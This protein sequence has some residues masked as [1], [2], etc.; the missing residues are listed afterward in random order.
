MTF[1]FTALIEGEVAGCLW[2]ATYLGP[3][4][5]ISQK[6][7]F[8]FQVF[9]IFFGH[10]VLDNA[11]G[12]EEVK[13]VGLVSRY[14]SF[15]VHLPILHYLVEVYEELTGSDI[16]L[17]LPF[18]DVICVAPSKHKQASRG[19]LAVERRERWLFHYTRQRKCLECTC[20]MPVVSILER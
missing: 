8:S 5:R 3:G 18:S 1:V 4:T 2:G 17:F 12:I 9:V 7:S 13:D 14:L 15:V 10:V 19:G 11:W 20:A 16:A 6:S